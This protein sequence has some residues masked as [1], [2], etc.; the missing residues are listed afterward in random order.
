M[1][2]VCLLAVP[3]AGV[4]ADVD[5]QS[6]EGK[7][8]W[9]TFPR[10]DESDGKEAKPFLAISAKKAGDNTI[11]IKNDALGLDTTIVMTA[12]DNRYK[13]V[14]IDEKY[15]YLTTGDDNND[16]CF[17]SLH[18]L[19]TDTISLYA[20]NWPWK[21]ESG[22]KVCA[23]FDVANILP[24]PSLKDQHIIQAY[25][26]SDH[27]GKAACQGSHFA[28]IAIEDNTIVDY[29]PTAFTSAINKAIQRRDNGYDLTA[30]EQ[31]LVN[32][33]I[34]DTLHT[35]ALKKGQV[36]YVWTGKGDGSDHDLTG[37]WVKS[38]DHKKIAVFNGV[39]HTNIPY[40][41]R[42]RDQL[43]EQAMPTQYWGTKFAVTASQGRYK[44]RLAILALNDETDVHIKYTLPD[45]S[46]KD[47]LAHTFNFTQDTKRYWE[48]EYNTNG[49]NFKFISCFIETS[50][51]CAVH[52]VMVSNAHDQDKNAPGDPS[53]AWLN[54][55]EQVISDI[56]FSTFQNYNHYVNIITDTANV[57]YMHLLGMSQRADSSL[58]NAF[59]TLSGNKAYMY[60]R[61]K[62]D[63]E[64]KAYTLKGKT[65]FVANVYGLGS[66]ESYSY[67][68]GGATK[69]LTQAITISTEDTT[70]VFSPDQENNLCGR[71]TIQF[72]CKPDYEFEK[73]VWHFGDGTPDVTVYDTLTPAPHYYSG[74]QDYDATCSIYRSSSNLCAG[75]SAVDVI[76]IKVTVG[77][78][79]FSIGEANIPCPVNGVQGPGSIPYTSTIDLNGSD[80]TVGFDDAAKA[81]GFTKN[82]L[83]IKPDHFE[84]NIPSTAEPGVK[85]GIQ[86]EIDSDCGD[87][88]AVLPFAL[89]VGN[90]VI[91]QRYNNVLGLLKDHKSLKGLSLS[92]FQW[93][94]ASD[95]TALEGQV[96]SNLNMYD[97]PENEY[98][99]DEFYICYWVN[100]GQAD[101][102]YNC[103]CAKPFIT[104]GKQHQF[105]TNPDSLIITASYSYQHGEKVFVNAN[106]GGKT[107]IECYAQWITTDGR[108]YK[109]LKF[110]I[111][112][113]GCT[114]DTPAQAG[115]YMLRVVTD[116]KTRSFKFIIK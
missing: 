6:T 51:P 99:N 58:V 98:K 64:P 114:I 41:V 20:G 19:S 73:I 116:K 25:S 2:L 31:L 22:K 39:P 107:D 96:T 35:P 84:L 9:L 88:I 72:A 59:D 87:T 33:K 75:Q 5:G 62:L 12:A 13:E 48:F 80:V 29:C 47:S 115:L 50:C 53:L 57:K 43:F 104:D 28:I 70:Y 81:A 30:D 40:Q 44:D 60:A 15:C 23:S 49:A 109:D 93:Y 65:G 79:S 112:N 102:Y 97:L 67:S 82:D 76:N 8:F 36:Y 74:T 61:I 92:D 86:I 45:G 18:V 26:P 17:K 32:F 37:S 90:D 42:N 4:K 71:D 27:D 34:G 105:D 111:P 100:K 21:L 77:R 46:I 108:I 56:T 94:R 91:D 66:K 106:W 11:T 103:A 68:V 16:S 55:I 63:N 89:P 113:G 24:Q 3:F 10:A 110:N 52:Q 101:A 85:Y 38:R 54:P 69:P 7:E 78:Y 83:K 95:S 14:E 1:L